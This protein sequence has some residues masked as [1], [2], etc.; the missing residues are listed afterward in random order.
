MR[1]VACFDCELVGGQRVLGTKTAL[2]GALMVLMRLLTR[3]ADLLTMLVLA[4]LLSPANFGLVAIAMTMISILEATLELPLSQALV[5]LPE[6]TPAYCDTAFTLGTLRGVVLCVLSCASAVPFA[7]FYGQPELVPLICALSIAPAARGLVNPRLA[8]F[9]KDLNFKWEFLFELSAKLVACAIS[10]IV[11][12]LT[13]SYWSIAVCT[14]AGPIAVIMMSYTLLPF[15]PR[16]SLA[17]WRVFGDFLG[18][19]SLSQVIMAINS[20]SEQLILGKLMRPALLGQFSTANNLANGPCAILFIPILRPLLSAFSILKGDKPRLARSYRN[21][22]SAT[23]AIGLP[24]LVGVAFLAGPVVEL[25]LGPKWLDTI[26]MLHWLSLSLVP[27]LFAVPFFP[28]GMALNR[29]RQLTWCVTIQLCVKLP[30]VVA[31][32]LLYGFLGV[33]G[34]RIISECVTTL[35]CR[36]LVKKIL[37]IR[38]ISQLADCW[39]PVVAALAMLNVM[40]MSEPY[41]P[42]GHEMNDLLVQL[43]LGVAIGAVSYIGS[44]LILWLASGQPSGIEATA[45][46]MLLDMLRRP[47]P[48]AVSADSDGSNL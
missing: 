12:F 26:P 10:T 39:R 28:L 24:M 18:W 4:R 35:Y 6:I 30:L 38:V 14:I 17:E 9:A 40:E 47:R 5:R 45:S 46:R 31:G 34:A 48:I 36:V 8:Q 2:S 15:R 41:L 33:I 20:Q 13:H 22:A 44:L 32:A 19:M 3:I 29:T 7:R 25:L 11:A 23:V 37:D 21:A 42:T 43:L 27:G 1:R 16:L